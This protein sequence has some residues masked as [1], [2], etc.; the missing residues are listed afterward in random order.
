M[1]NVVKVTTMLRISDLTWV[2][3]ISCIGNETAILTADALNKHSR[4][5]HFWD[6]N[7]GFELDLVQEEEIK[8]I[9]ISND[10]PVLIPEP[11]KISLRELQSLYKHAYVRTDM[12]NK[13]NLID[14]SDYVDFE[15]ISEELLEAYRS[16]LRG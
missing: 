14:W 12:Y 5:T 4:L 13:T 8:C 15:V 2:A 16:K 3:V 11:T 7:S 9:P 10:M 1:K 6:G